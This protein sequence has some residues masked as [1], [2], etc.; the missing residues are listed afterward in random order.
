MAIKSNASKVPP[1]SMEYKLP[2]GGLL[3][4]KSDDAEDFPDKVTVHPFDFVTES[5]L[6]SNMT[7]TDKSLRILEAV[8]DFPKGFDA[9]NLLVA[10]EY[11]ILAIARALTYGETYKF[12]T[13][14]P[15]PSCSH[16]EAHNMLIPD[17]LPIKVWSKKDV[18]N[19]HVQLPNIKDRVDLRFLTVG[20]EVIIQKQ[21]EQRESLREGFDVKYLRK[22]A[23]H[24]RAVNNEEIADYSEAEEYLR[25]N[26]KG[27]D[28]V[29]FKEAIL[30]KSCG[31]IPNWDIECDKC[32]K[33]YISSIPI[34]RHF[35]R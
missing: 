20:D 14:C 28:M 16:E 17:E 27:A 18:S 22:M 31:I 24:I 33:Q 35:F 5:I 1:K 10:D 32:G 34:V 7:S 3:Y 26:V 9:R 12:A 6:L 21:A 13:I 11:V 19:L 8:A 25:N 15:N 29:A 4:E 23:M 2:S 30:E